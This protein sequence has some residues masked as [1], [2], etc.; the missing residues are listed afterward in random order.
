MVRRFSR[1]YTNVL[2]L[3]RDGLLDTPYSLSEGR[4]IFELAQT[5]QTDLSDLRSALD[6]DA[7]Y[8]SRILGRLET[9]GILRRERSTADARR[10]IIL[11]T[12]CGR[13]EF[14]VLDARSADQVRSLLS[15]LSED[16]QDR[17]VGAMRDIEGVLAPMS[18]PRTVVLRAPGSG[19]F[20]WVV[21][22]H[23][24]L[25][26]T[27]YGWD[28]SFESLVARIVADYVEH[29]EPERQAAWIAEVDGQ[30]VG[31]VF[32]MQKT[33]DVAQLRLLLVEPAARGLGIGR[34]LVEECMG[35]ARRAGYGRMTLWTNDV[36][37]SARRIY[38]RVG[39]ELVEEEKHHSFGQDLVGQTWELVL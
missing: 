17:L 35:F 31:C 11:L 32:C 33:L 38:E 26:A 23:G 7:G 25:Y 24:T 2:G 6:L 5:E 19:D 22:R 29:A 3:L 30:R 28:Q 16:G 18:S 13:Q 37:D 14:E 10:Q 27:E 36:L 21:E 1:L 20:G 4:V 39:F 12:E 9:K 15:A 8:L 34:R